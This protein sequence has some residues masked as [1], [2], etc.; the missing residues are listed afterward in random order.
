MRV[1]FRLLAAC[2]LLT[3]ATASALAQTTA[4]T[5]ASVAAPLPTHVIRSIRPADTDFADLEFLRQEIGGAR[6]VMLGEP[7]H[8]EGNVSEA[9]IR[10]MRFL[11]ERMGFT[12]VAFESGFYELDR[13][14]RELQ[15]SASA[16][17]VIDNSVFGVWT[18]TR[19][20][21]ELLPLLGPGKLKVAGF[22]YQLSGA[23]QDELLDELEAFLKP[24]KGAD[25]IAYD[26]L[27]ECISMM[28]EH[29]LF[30][31]S[32]QIVLFNLQ[33]N[34][35]RKLLEKVAA[36]PDV[37]RR[38][39]AAFWLQNLRSLQALAHDYATNDPGVKDST[40]WTPTTS[41]PRDAQMADNLLWYARQ[42]PQEK[43]ICW[44]ALPHLANQVGALNSVETNGFRPMGQAVK[45][46]L[47]AEA[48]YVLG[49]LAG[50]GTHGFGSWGKYL[51]VPTPAPG[52]LEA[53]L[54]AQGAEYSFMSLK[55]AAPGH[56]LTT[57]AFDY[58]PMTG[59]WSKV[60]DGFLFLKTVNPPHGAQSVAGRSGNDSVVTASSAPPIP[61]VNSPS[62]VQR[63]TTIKAGGAAFTLSGAVLDRK[64]GQPVPF[65]TV[66]VPARSAGT[67]TDAQGRFR[68][69]TRRG[70]LVQVSSIGYEPSTLTAT[71]SG[72]AL[73]V[74][75]APAAFA[76]ADVRVSAQ[77]Q[78]PKRIMK[79]V[80]KA[81][82][83]NY[84]QQDYLAQVYT[85]RRISNFDTLQTE[86]EYISQLFEPAGYQHR[87][88]GFLFMGPF[89]KHRVQ[90]KHIVV[91]PQDSTRRTGLPIGSSAETSDPVRTS[92]L[93]KSAT[94]S[95]F[96]LRLDTIRPYDGATV[97]VL[98]F[99]VKRA[100]H[101]STGNYL[102]AGY[103]GKVYVR[104][105]NYAVIRYEA[106]WQFDT[107][108]YNA[109]SHKY[110]GRNNQISRLYTEVFSDNRTANI[111]LYQKG[112]NGRYHP[113]E[114]SS[115]S[116]AIGRKLGGKPFYS[117]GATREYFTSLPADTALLPL[118]PKI[119]PRI[120]EFLPVQL[121]HTPY[122]PEFWQTYQRPVP[123]EPAP[124]LEA[125]K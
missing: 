85:H 122:R 70:E 69:E 64:T 121:K 25:G 3:T 39:R 55:H 30:P 12:T 118:N 108:R 97:Y 41:N 23:Y 107:T 59:P 37:K 16:A 40:E 94:L 83:T 75:L 89:Q 81:I 67:V 27:D 57:Y 17:E 18:S 120:A 92:P 42:H 115:Q 1:N 96:V 22:D 32:H 78:D 73:S 60:V 2:C 106:L 34:K 28:G 71:Q 44:G 66:A 50:G 29:F 109:I 24:E 104:Q 95:K 98:N 79:K 117:Q 56:N 15:K 9:K 45:E 88:G 112:A 110:Y 14:Q 49:T 72:A 123:A 54:L 77:S 111:V 113:A 43:I 19:E 114:S 91:Q 102:E 93:F 99:S 80:I 13:A 33:V 58:R 46:G 26:Y 61:L 48:V 119:E 82:E 21:R 47:G 68:L 20:F 11:Q 90:E 125:G 35:A 38:E 53:E 124:P 84:E 65:A 5:M 63:T 74:R 105:D 86:V 100:T 8:G 31:P 101:R 62:P 76:L 51:P 116:L 103:S 7:T 6:V 36:G 10:L 4:T 52:T 87:D